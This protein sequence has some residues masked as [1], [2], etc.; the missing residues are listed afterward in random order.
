LRAGGWTPDLPNAATAKG[1]GTEVT[2]LPTGSLLHGEQPPSPAGTR[3]KAAVPGTCLCALAR[4]TAACLVRLLGPVD[5][6]AHRLPRRPG[7]GPGPLIG[8]VQAGQGALELGHHI[9]R[10]ELIAAE[11]LV[12]GG[13]VLGKPYQ[14]ATEAPTPLVQA[15][16]GRNTVIRRAD[17]P[18]T[19]FH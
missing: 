10:H 3:G 4:P 19:R 15:L 16:D 18:L 12:S 6:L 5:R 14:E 9:A 17:N 13:E 7:A 8:H 2:K 1:E 11:H